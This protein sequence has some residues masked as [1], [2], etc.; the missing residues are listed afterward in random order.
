[1]T[2]IYGGVKR[3][4]CHVLIRGSILSRLFV[5]QQH[6]NGHVEMAVLPSHTAVAAAR[7][8]AAV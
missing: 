3:G 5:P 7:A 2:F 4:R 8:D 6:L 1:M